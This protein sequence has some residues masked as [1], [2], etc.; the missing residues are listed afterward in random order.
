M[1]APASE[2]YRRN[3]LL[4]MFPAATLERVLPHMNFVRL[5]QKRLLANGQEHESIYFPLDALTVLTHSDEFART[6]GVAL[7][8]CDGAIGVGM[9]LG[10]RVSVHDVAIVIEGDALCISRNA[11]MHE[12]DHGGDFGDVLRRYAHAL[13]VQ[14]SF[15]AFCERMHSIEQRLIRWLL[16]AGERTAHTGLTLSHD[17]LASV[18]GVRREGVSVAAG[19]LRKAEL[20]QYQR[21]RIVIVDRSRMEALACQCY[22]EIRSEYARLSEEES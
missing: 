4:S 19:K 10:S 6:G 22:R 16:L 8:G 14:I 2:L 11:V 18:I 17:T 9:A 15:T 21:G 3:Q 1:I 7:A 12:L 20:I 13:L 5:P